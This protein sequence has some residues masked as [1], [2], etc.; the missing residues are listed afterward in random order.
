MELDDLKTLWKEADQRLGA[1]ESALRLSRR[2]ASAD[3]LDRMRS[4]LRFVHLALWYE[5]AFGVLACL[6]VGSYLFDHLGEIRFALPAA[7]LH[8]GAIL[9]LGSAIRQ[10]VALGQIDYAGPVVQIQRRLTELRVLRARTN[11][12]V[13][14]SSPLLWAL[15]II[16]VPH[17]L[18]GLDVYR[19]FGWPWV[20]GNL[21][22]GIAI[23]AA[24]AWLYRRFPAA[25]Q[26][27]KILRWMGD[28]ITGR[29]VATVSGFLEDLS[30]FEAGN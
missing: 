16:V 27:S 7:G 19:A 24:I 29:K 28:D 21:A 4:K 9:V 12:W 10:L 8:L 6:M 2:L 18:I 17:G 1:M 25:A 20:G 26:S 13:L 15:L 23:L 14:L 11:R 22:F 5:I 3:S 30:A